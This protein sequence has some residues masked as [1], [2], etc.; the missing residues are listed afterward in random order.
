MTKAKTNPLDAAQKEM[1]EILNSQGDFTYCHRG[2][3]PATVRLHLP[4]Q[5]D[6]ELIRKLTG[7]KNTVSCLY[8][9][10]QTG[11]HVYYR[12][13][14]CAG[15]Q[16]CYTVHRE[17]IVTAAT[18]DDMTG[19]VALCDVDEASLEEMLSRDDVE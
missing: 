13:V 3:V 7:F 6:L 15:A 2:S 4:L 11:A 18:Y 9:H 1:Y 5:S 14:D 10:V 12:E 8:R 17:I 16:G 19:A